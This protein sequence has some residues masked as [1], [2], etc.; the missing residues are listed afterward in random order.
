MI[1]DP[2]KI[3]ASI[4]LTLL[5]SNRNAFKI[6]AMGPKLHEI[7]VISCTT[8]IG[9]FTGVAFKLLVPVIR[10]A[11]QFCTVMVTHVN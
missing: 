1:E 11:N 10:L 7:S 4:D 3:L 8:L 2:L 6:F 9:I 5:A